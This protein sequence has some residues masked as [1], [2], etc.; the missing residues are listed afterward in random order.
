MANVT[1]VAV[2]ELLKQYRV[3]AG[4]TQEALAERARLSVRAISDLERGVRRSPHKD[5]IALLSAAL[6][7]D[8]EERQRL[9]TASLRP[10]RVVRTRGAG[11]QVRYSAAPDIPATVTGDVVPPLTPILGREREEAAV[12][13]LLAQPETRLLTLIGPPGVGK[14]RLAL[15]VAVSARELFPDG[16]TI[17]ALAAI[18]DPDLVLPSIARILGVDATGAQCLDDAL[19]AHLRD[20]V[21]LLVLDNFEQVAAAGA[22]VANV[23][24]VCRG[25]KVLVTS[26]GTLQVRG[27]HQFE[28]PPLAVPDE[29]ATTAADN[30][31][32]Y[33]AVALFVQRARDIKPTF[34]LTPLSAPVVAA[35]CRRLDGLPLAIELA[36]ARI[37]LLPPA[38]LLTRL[39]TPLRMLSGGPRDLPQ[40]QQTLRRAI[41]WSYE[42]LDPREQRLWRHL[43][44]FSG[45]WTLDDAESL[46]AMNEG[47]ESDERDT[48]DSLG[49]LVSKSL[50][51][52]SVL[53][54]GEP[55]FLLLETLREYALEQL[56]ICGEMEALRRR[57]ALTYLRLAEEAGPF[58][59]GPH[60]DTWLARL[61]REHDNLRA[62]LRWAEERGELEIGLRLAAALWWFWQVRGEL[63]EGRG[64]LER[65]VARDAQAGFLAPAPARAAALEGAGNLA[66]RQSDYARAIAALEESLPLYRDLQDHQSVSNV[67]NTLGIIASE[68]GD[69]DR[70]LVL[71]AESL[72]LRREMNLTRG[73]GATLTNLG[74]VAYLRADFASAAQFYAESL[75]LLRHLGDTW[76]IA[77]ALNNLGSAFTELKRHN[78]ALALLEESLA[79][80]RELGD[81]RSIA[82]ALHNLGEAAYHHGDL[83]RA[84]E[85]HR[86][87]VRL[88]AEV[89]YTV[90]IIEALEGLAEALCAHGAATEAAHMCGLSAALR[91]RAGIPR[92][93]GAIAAFE[94]AVM[95]LRTQLG[96]DGFAACWAV[97][98]QM[99]IDEAL[100]TT[101]LS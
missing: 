45:G 96:D 20:R 49:S 48:L 43:S 44:V 61:S 22:R 97:G 13:H 24:A 100:A 57:H 6:A 18:L 25:L 39:E 95:M 82:I 9:V 3:A 36:A 65:L 15:Q 55:R 47:A 16:I 33:A 30:L 40:R 76:A 58:L 75:T 69:F 84:A 77:T 64:W 14:T 85:L 68:Q 87:S 90:G 28:V 56:E 94:R 80:Q 21:A 81:R 67:L 32:R 60:Q 71:L 42:L 10:P 37:Q 66:S 5:T 93:P 7:L 23:L 29:Q 50:V 53:S 73:I 59:K 19:I 74:N 89:G 98:E 91:T 26:R 86:E 63:T 79:L 54:D 4:L 101:Q 1:V 52:S 72:T 62:A 8:D 31:T 88:H 92:P 78:E 70:A 46:C 12:L 99:S 34:A 11:A 41:D 38:T 17:V 51:V 35:I 2:A 83:P 27:E